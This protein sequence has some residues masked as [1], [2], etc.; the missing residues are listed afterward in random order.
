MAEDVSLRVHLEA[1]LAASD[2]RYA[3]LAN[4]R[5]ARL[6]ERWDAQNKALEAAFTAAREALQT[7]L[8]ELKAQL[9]LLNEL[10]TG[11]L[12]RE[13][14]DAKHEI[15]KAELASMG[16]R[17]AEL[18]TAVAVGPSEIRDL[19][20][21]QALASGSSRGLDRSG[22]LQR[23]WMYIL[24]AGIAAATAIASLLLH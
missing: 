24:I 2:R 3:E 10:R 5:M 1:L 13:E 6:D 7:A 20:R 16:E 12:T 17:V 21:A 4:E 14:Y 8:V 9:A 23:E 15:L 18:V 11:V 19:E 22:K